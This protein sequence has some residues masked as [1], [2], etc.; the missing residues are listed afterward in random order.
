VI[1][2]INPSLLSFSCAEILSE[3]KKGDE[4]EDGPSKRDC[5][6]LSFYTSDTS[7]PSKTQIHWKS[8]ES[9]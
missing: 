9:V 2:R 5:C 3:R 7:K 4:K 1:Y 6:F 8:R